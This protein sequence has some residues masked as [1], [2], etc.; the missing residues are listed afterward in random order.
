M[1]HLVLFHKPDNRLITY[2]DLVPAMS[3]S[4]DTP[5][6]LVYAEGIDGDKYAVRIGDLDNPVLFHDEQSVANAILH[7]G[8]EMDFKEGAFETRPLDTR[9]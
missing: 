2:G 9:I 3:M 8:K 6:G 7:L 1:R 5:C 4:S